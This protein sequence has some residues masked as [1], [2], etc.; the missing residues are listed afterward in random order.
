MDYW[1]DATPLAPGDRSFRPRL[2][3]LLPG[4]RLSG[5]DHD[6]IAAFAQANG[7]EYDALLARRGEEFRSLVVHGTGEA[8]V[9]GAGTPGL[10]IGNHG[11]RFMPGDLDG[12]SRRGY[13]AVRHGLDLP[14]IFWDSRSPDAATPLNL[15]S[16]ALEVAAMLD[17]SEGAGSESSMS[18]FR[19]RSTW[20]ELHERLAGTDAGSRA[21]RKAARAAART[22][23]GEA[24]RA[25]GYGTRVEKGRE[26]EAAALL[27]AEA[28]PVVAGLAES[29][30]VEANGPWLLAHSK[31]GDLSTR[32]PRVWAWAFS[33]ASRL[34][35]LAA[36]WGAEV[37]DLRRPGWYTA[38]R[39]DRP[40]R[41]DG[42][43]ASL[44]P[45]R[46]RP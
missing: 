13:V 4:G 31:F 46:R 1:F 29:F 20:L 11:L 45:Q 17:W 40:A 9:R 3:R 8:V 2:D 5:E 32:D 15:A 28:R 26:G 16:K 34:V 6:A 24:V 36:L 44:L 19:S 30:D 41:L 21:T 10:E 23:A 27:S 42:A 12:A 38:Q 43:L 33:A 14:H 22:A 7:L 37:A 25:Q 35:D 39:V 18:S